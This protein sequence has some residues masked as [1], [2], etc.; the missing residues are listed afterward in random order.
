[1]VVLLLTINIDGDTAV[2]LSMIVVIL[3]IINTIANIIND[4]ISNSINATIIHCNHH[5]MITEQ[6]YS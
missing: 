1:M 4:D 5:L 2:L 3:I 6:I